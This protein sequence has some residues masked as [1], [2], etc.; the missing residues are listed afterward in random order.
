[1]AQDVR[2]CPKPHFRVLPHH[3]DRR[4]IRWANLGQRR[5]WSRLPS[6]C[7][8]SPA[9]EQVRFPVP[10]RPP[11]TAPAPADPA[12]GCTSEPCRRRFREALS[13][14]TLKGGLC[15]T[16]GS[17]DHTVGVVIHGEGRDEKDQRKEPIDESPGECKAVVA[18]LHRRGA[19]DAA[20]RAAHH[21]PDDRPR[22]P[23]TAGFPARGCAGGRGS[24]ADLRVP[25]RSLLPTPDATTGRCTTTKPPRKQWIARHYIRRILPSTMRSW[26]IAERS[27][28][29]TIAER[30][31]A[32]AGQGRIARPRP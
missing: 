5:A 26:T 7:S 12:R 19:G 15:D 16:G 18:V 10:P 1:M 6:P 30:G 3:S 21:C 32:D 31:Y 27:S 17:A 2:F 13:P 23:A 28:R 24:L 25:C 22:P 8:G 4:S 29:L 14:L 9:A 20:A 11:R